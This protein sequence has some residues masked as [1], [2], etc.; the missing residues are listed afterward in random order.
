MFFFLENKEVRLQQFFFRFELVNLPFHCLFTALQVE[1][2]IRKY[3]MGA[4]GIIFC[5]QDL[6]SIQFGFAPCSPG[7][8]FGVE[9]AEL[10]EHFGVTGRSGPGF[11]TPL[12]KAR[13]VE[14]DVS[15]HSM[16]SFICVTT[17][18][19]SYQNC[20]KWSKIDKIIFI[21]I[22]ILWSLLM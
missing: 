14:R 22:D 17:L 12:I 2:R 6:K 18:K 9:D 16:I 4:G 10:V 7:F 8:F 20:K 11:S 19:K 1:V 3:N 13:F 15:R 21:L 5:Y